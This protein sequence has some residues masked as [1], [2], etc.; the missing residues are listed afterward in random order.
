MSST[1]TNKAS[2]KSKKPW[3]KEL[4]WQ[5]A[6]G[7]ILGCLVGVLIRS[8]SLPTEYFTP[9]F[10]MGGKVF[11][12]LLKMVVLPL[13]IA[14][15]LLGVMGVGSSKELSRLGSRTMFYY[16]VTS[17]LSITTG[18]IFVNLI[19]PGTRVSV[20]IEGMTGKTLDAPTSFSD[21]LL[22]MI[23]ENPFHAMAAVPFDMLAVLFFVIALGVFSLQVTKEQRK[24]LADFAESINAIMLKMV[25]GILFLAPIGVF[26]LVADIV[27]DVGMGVF[28]SLGWY[29]ATVILALAFHFLVIVPLIYFLIRKENPYDYM[30]QMSPALLTAFSSASSAATLSLTMDCTQKNKK[31]SSKVSSIVLPL[32]ATV[33]MDGTALYEGVAVLFIAQLMGVD[34]AMGQQFLILLTALLASIGAAGIPHAGLAMMVVILEVVGLPLEATGLLLAV[35]RIVDMARTAVNVWSDSVGAAVIE[36]VIEPQKR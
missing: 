9:V 15:L 25:E 6:I 3:Y 30:K 32:G 31:V 17:L 24:P 36:K 19:S 27:T 10:S 7:L 12:R 35:D 14:S 2:T 23:P 4:H 13:V 20:D 8:F 1:K 18:L 16:I 5:I 11:L 21:I 29:L 33:N 26:C 34:L 22:R 28:L